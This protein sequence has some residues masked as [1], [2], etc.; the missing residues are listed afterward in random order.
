M[1]AL[2]RTD[3]LVLAAL[4]GHECSDG[5]VV[6]QWT[7]PKHDLCYNGRSLT[8]RPVLSTEPIVPGGSVSLHQAHAAKRE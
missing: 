4:A 6:G 1:A 7:A 3:G 2:D 5:M 8:R